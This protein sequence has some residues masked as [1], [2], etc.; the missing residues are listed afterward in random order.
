ML[1]NPRKLGTLISVES[2]KMFDI[3]SG[4]RDHQ[5]EF[6]DWVFLMS[7]ISGWSAVLWQVSS[8]LYDQLALRATSTSGKLRYSRC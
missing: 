5:I 8:I 6:A 7:H 4:V 3:M 1:H 2:N